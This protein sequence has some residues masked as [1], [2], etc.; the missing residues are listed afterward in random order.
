MTRDCPCHERRTQGPPK[1]SSFK[2]SSTERQANSRRTGI[3]Q[4]ITVC[5]IQMTTQRSRRTIDREFVC[6][7]SDIELKLTE[8][9]RR[10]TRPTSNYCP[11]VNA[12]VEIHPCL[13][14]SVGRIWPLRVVDFGQRIARRTLLGLFFITPPSW[15]VSMPANLGCYLKALGV[16]GPFF[17]D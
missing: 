5:L 4:L 16:I 14:K 13:Q 7:R 9:H 6:E 2:P 17:V 15:L 11:R 12:A 8:G 3:S 10:A 1:C